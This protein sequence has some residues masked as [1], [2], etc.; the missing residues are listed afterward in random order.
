LYY[1]KFA[2]AEKKGTLFARSSYSVTLVA[3]IILISFVLVIFLLFTSIGKSLLQHLL[4]GTFA[5][6]VGYV[7][8]FFSFVVAAHFII[9]KNLFLPHYIIYPTL[10]KEDRVNFKN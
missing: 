7:I 5:T 8:K 9:V 3:K 1:K 4:S 2:I 10:E 6:V